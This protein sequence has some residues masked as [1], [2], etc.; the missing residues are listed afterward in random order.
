MNHLDSE[1]EILEWYIDMNSGGTPH[2][3]EEIEIVKN[4][5]NVLM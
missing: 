5:I 1:K 4:M 3:D 2:T